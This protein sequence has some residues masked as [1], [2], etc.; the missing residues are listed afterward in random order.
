MPPRFGNAPQA[1]HDR[2]AAE[3]Y[4]RLAEEKLRKFTD[5]SSPPDLFATQLVTDAVAAA[6][7]AA[8]LATP[9]KSAHSAK[10]R[11]VTL[12]AAS[13]ASEDEDYRRKSRP[14]S[15]TAKSKARKRKQSERK[16][17]G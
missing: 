12:S 9:S 5:V 17:S 6:V 3:Q 14:A 4:V 11:R 2:A 16:G 10:R 13:S 8:K 1:R 7:S 15:Q